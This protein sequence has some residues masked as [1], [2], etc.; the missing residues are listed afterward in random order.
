MGNIPNRVKGVKP[1]LQRV[2]VLPFGFQAFEPEGFFIVV[3]F[4]DDIIAIDD[5]IALP[6]FIVVNVFDV[7]GGNRRIGMCN[8]FSIEQTCFVI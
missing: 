8:G 5:F 2:V 7:G 6:L 4:G 1:I 3:K